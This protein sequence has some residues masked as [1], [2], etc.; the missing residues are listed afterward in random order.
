MSQGKKRNKYRMLSPKHKHKAIE[1]AGK[2]GIKTASDI[3]NVPIKS[4]K[5]WM[6]VGCNRKKGGGR[7]TKD[8]KMESD[9]HSWYLD[10]E[11]K[12]QVITGKM[13]KHKALEFSNCR[14][15]IAS[16]GWLDKFKQ[17]YDMH[18]Q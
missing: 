14:D 1:M 10:M 8:P 9:L 4:L 7:K 17:R 11:S 16:K 15:F 12:H 6:I 13:I 5:R 18:L 2:V 3:C